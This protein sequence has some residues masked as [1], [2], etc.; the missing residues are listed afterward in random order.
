MATLSA[1]L[2]KPLRPLWISP[3]TRIWIN[4]V[5]HPTELAFLPLI[6]LSASIPIPA[7]LQHQPLWRHARLLRGGGAS[8]GRGGEGQETFTY[9]Y[10]PGGGDDEETW[11]EGLTPELLWMHRWE[12]VGAG[13]QQISAQVARLVANGGC[14]GAEG[15]GEQPTQ[16]I[17]GPTV[18]L[19]LVEVVQ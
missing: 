16:L 12:L 8:A 11:A 19:T 10:V 5:P 15:V 3:S 2:H 14:S 18:T 4:Q 9:C 6:L 13:P 1:A 7:S 17:C